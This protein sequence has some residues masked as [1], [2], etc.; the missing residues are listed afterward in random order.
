MSLGELDF[1]ERLRALATHPGARGLQDDAAVIGDLVFTHD[2][3]A[4]GV[5]YLPTDP[6]ASVGWKL[7]TV[8]LSDLAAKGAEPVAAL[9]GF[10]LGRDDEWDERFL[11]GVAAACETYEIALVGGDTIALPKGAPR[12][13]GLTAIGRGGPAIP[14]RSDGK[15]GDKLWLAGTLGDAAAGLDALR[16]DPKAEGPLIEAYRRPVPQLAVGRLLAPHARAM[17]DLS[18]GL[19]IDASRLCRA[20]RCSARIDLDRLPI[21]RAYIAERGADRRARLAAATG[22]D[23]YALLAALPA[24]FDP[25]S[26]SLPSGTILA[27]IGTLGQGEGLTLFDAAGEVPLPEQLG[28]EH[29][30]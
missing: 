3:I 12:V 25:L 17:M 28:Y 22:G 2:M 23:D 11:S 27:P 20:S 8:N 9:M 16:A 26:L 4:E 1:I 29:R 13:F 14:S 18:D 24:D 19:L 30:A 7:V 5:H 6:A 21:S 10:T 15:P